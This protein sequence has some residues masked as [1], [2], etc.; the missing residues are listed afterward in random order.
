MKQ[1]ITITVTS[2]KMEIMK[3]YYQ[4]SFIPITGE[5]IDF[6]AKVNDVIITGYL[7]KKENKKVTFF[8][9]EALLE[10]KIWDPDAE[11]IEKEKEEVSFAGL[12]VAEQ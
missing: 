4:D 5:Y 11:L 8:G 7:S 3:N 12:L 1:N 2:I 9:E 10:A 6:Q